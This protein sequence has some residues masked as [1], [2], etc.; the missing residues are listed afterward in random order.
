MNHMPQGLMRQEMWKRGGWFKAKLKVEEN[1]QGC[2]TKKRQFPAAQEMRK[3]GEAGPF[4]SS[5]ILGKR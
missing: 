3:P 1:G 4:V 2:L 5:K